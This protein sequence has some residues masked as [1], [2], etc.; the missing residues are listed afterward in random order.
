VTGHFVMQDVPAN[1]GEA[2]FADAQLTVDGD[3]TPLGPI[4]VLNCLLDPQA[5]DLYIS[6]FDANYQEEIKKHVLARWKE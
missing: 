3:R 4:N 2:M 6:S 1:P 5:T